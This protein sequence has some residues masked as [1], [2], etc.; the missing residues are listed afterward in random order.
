MRARLTRRARRARA[1][2]A[3][4]GG[5]GV[6]PHATLPYMPTR[7]LSFFFVGVRLIPSVYCRRRFLMGDLSEDAELVREVVDLR[8]GAYEMMLLRQQE[9]AL[10]RI[11][12]RIEKLGRDDDE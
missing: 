11:A 7:M 8:E 6:D 1:V 10:E 3:Y 2:C 12:E 9:V 5:H 4:A